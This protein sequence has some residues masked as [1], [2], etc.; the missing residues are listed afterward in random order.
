[1]TRL[2]SNIPQPCPVYN[3]ALH[4]PRVHTR[5]DSDD[6]SGLCRALHACVRIGTSSHCPNYERNDQQSSHALVAPT[7]TPRSLGEAVSLLPV[8]AAP[9]YTA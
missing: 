2:Y 4:L 9:L 1:M 3:V 5:M 6:H 7:D 8:P